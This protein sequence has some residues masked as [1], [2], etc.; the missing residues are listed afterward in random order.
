MSQPGL[1][2]PNTGSGPD[3]W[4]FSSTLLPEGGG[5]LNKCLNGEALP[6]GTTPY[7]LIYH[8][9]EKGTPFI[10]LLLTNGTPFTYFV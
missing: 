6:R 3:R 4:Q 10:Y 9:H 5:V 7:P 8:F 1:S 2:I